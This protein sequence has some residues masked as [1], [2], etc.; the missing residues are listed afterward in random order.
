MQDAH[1]TCKE[2]IPIVVA[3]AIWGRHWQNSTV[4]VLCDNEAVVTIV[5]KGTTKDTECMHL[6]RCLAFIKAKFNV[7]LVASH[8]KGKL[9]TLADALSRNCLT[10]FHALHPQA[11]G[12]PK[13]IPAPL[14]DLLLVQRPDWTSQ[15]WAQ[16]WDVQSCAQLDRPIT[17]L[18]GGYMLIVFIVLIEAMLTRR[19]RIDHNFSLRKHSLLL[20]L[21]N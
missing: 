20:A 15:S 10:T 17:P 7:Y 4:Q 18:C 1:I 9:N 19:Q 16:L 5:N 8:I 12:E 6:V 21:T 11:V 14:L 2:L 13:G 3:T